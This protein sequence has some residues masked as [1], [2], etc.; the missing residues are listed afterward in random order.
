MAQQTAPSFVDNRLALIGNTFLQD[1]SGND[2]PARRR[3]RSLHGGLHQAPGDEHPCAPYQDKQVKADKSV[4][5]EALTREDGSGSDRETLMTAFPDDDSTPSSSYGYLLSPYSTLAKPDEDATEDDDAAAA[6]PTAKKHMTMKEM[7]AVSKELAMKAHA[8]YKASL[9]TRRSRTWG[10]AASELD[11]FDN[12]PL[13]TLLGGRSGRVCF[14]DTLPQDA[15]ETRAAKVQLKE[16]TTK[17]DGEAATQQDESSM[18]I[19]EAEAQHRELAVNAHAQYHT[20]RQASRARTWGGY[21]STVEPDSEPAP[22]GSYPSLLSRAEGRA[23]PVRGYANIDTSA[24]ERPGALAGD[25]VEFATATPPASN[26]TFPTLLGRTRPV[27]A[28]HSISTSMDMSDVPRTTTLRATTLLEQNNRTTEPFP[29]LLGSRM[30]QTQCV[31]VA[32][33]AAAVSPSIT[34]DE[35][36]ALQLAMYAREAFLSRRRRMQDRQERAFVGVVGFCV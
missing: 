9:R 18:T 5:K 7:E 28:S 22:Q 8:S 16:A 25:A 10:G 21:L 6:T 27:R 1:A 3:S 31:R 20:S 19:E 36:E 23:G 4:D 15:T 34:G 24:A 32:T 30:N 17:E 29:V 13:P 26:A 12:A 2:S 14:T 35:N 11:A 33:G